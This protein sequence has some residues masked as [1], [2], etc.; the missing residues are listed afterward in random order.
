MARKSTYSPEFK[1]RLVLQVLEGEKPLE[2]IASEHNLN[3]NMLRNWKSEFIKNSAAVS[4]TGTPKE[5]KE[6]HRREASLKKKNDQMLKTI[7]QLTLERDFLQDAF[8]FIGEEP[9]KLPEYDPK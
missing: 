1:A 2:Q 5:V 4:Q 7:G 6:S 9:P 3:P 8:R